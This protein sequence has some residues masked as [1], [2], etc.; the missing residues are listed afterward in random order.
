[1]PKRRIK[2]LL[3]GLLLIAGCKHSNEPEQSYGYFKTHF[4][5]ESQFVVETV[6]TDLAEQMFYAKFHQLPDA[7]QFR[8]TAAEKPGSPQDAPV[9]ELD[10]TFG[11][12]YPEVKSE[13]NVN[14]PIW[15]PDVYQNVAQD[16]A[17]A[18]SLNAG[19]P[20]AAEDTSM[21]LALTDG[22][23]VT[24]ENQNQE[25]S[26]A[27]ENN[28]SDPAL[29]EQ[30]AALLGA[31]AL[32]EHSGYFYDIRYPLS[33]MTAHLAMAHYLSGTNVFG[34]NGQMANAMLLTLMGDEAPAL[35][36][37]DTIGTN[38]TSVAPFV[39]A[40]QAENTGDYRPLDAAVGLS[41][42]ERA[43]WFCAEDGYIGGP[44]AWSKLTDEEKQNIDFVRIADQGNHSVEMGHQLLDE[45]LPLEMQEAASIYELSQQKKLDKANAIAALN[46]MP[47][48]CFVQSGK[49][50][51]VRVIGWGLWAAF[52]QRQIC[53]AVQQDFNM[54]NYMWGVPDDAKTFAQQCNNDFGALRLY[55]FVRRYDAV[56][57]DSYHKSV[58]DGIKVTVATP[59]LTPATCWNELFNHFGSEPRYVPIPNP[60]INEWH[61]HNPLP[62]T[63]YDLNPRLYHPSLVDRS[64]AVAVFERLHDL[65]PYDC[66]IIN[67]LIGKKY[68]N[69]P[70]YEQA[71]DLYSN[72]LPYSV[73]AI[74]QVSNTVTNDPVQYEKLML[75]GAK[76]SPDFNYNLADFYYNHGDEDKAEQYYDLACD[77]DPD[78]VHAS[79]YA[80]SRVRYYLKKGNVEKAKQIADD[81]AEVYSAVG[82]E[83]EALFFELTSN[84][85]S[86]FDWYSKIEERY[87]ESEE[88]IDFIMR[89]KIATGDTRFDDELKK[90][91]SNIFPKGIETVSLL[92]LHGPPADGVL[93]NGE[94]AATRAVGLHKGDVIVA[95]H[96]Y[97]MHN[98]Q[99]YTYAREWDPGPDM[100]FIV[101]QGNA[102]HKI[103]ASLPTHRF[104][105]EFGDYKAN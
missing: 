38:D 40:L 20:P 74:W 17:D 23:A 3:V 2:Y 55:P 21:L 5:T 67:F 53:F 84:Y 79:Y 63:V 85:D 33:R 43:A 96:G 60:H 88:M 95:I 13:L 94:N 99:Q 92:D 10:I 45:A 100:D 37:L 68:Q 83:A 102:Y 1:M 56:D 90:R 39:R 61:N 71:S 58:D 78:S 34:I 89:Y 91:T 32:R 35:K 86:A 9:Y 57:V 66:R 49:T 65:A 31:F 7:K 77:N 70:T 48:R 28:F 44:I 51:H 98:F 18:V 82:L 36:Q 12:K 30:A 72:V 73:Y 25:L 8:V 59:Q 6:V 62:G 87:N 101:W 46:E 27:L 19:S 80:S 4:Q 41:P 93:V 52:L 76:L 16:I 14:G 26:R 54:M 29:H 42:V 15:S 11:K 104:G 22:T 64:D 103:N 75:E 105:V 97:R 47:G 50:V 69:H 24:I 81:G